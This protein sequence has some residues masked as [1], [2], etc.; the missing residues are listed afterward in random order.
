MVWHAETGRSQIQG[1]PRQVRETQ[2][3]NKIKKVGEVAQHSLGTIPDTEII[4]SPALWTLSS[5]Y[6]LSLFQ[7]RLFLPG[8]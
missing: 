8:E 1:Q 5:F 2:A 3:Q 6:K 4:S 7:P